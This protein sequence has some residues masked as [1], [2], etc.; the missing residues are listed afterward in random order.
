MSFVF[1]SIGPENKRIVQ[2]EVY[3]KQSLH[4]GSRG[5]FSKQFRSAS[6]ENDTSIYPSTSGSYW[7]SLKVLYYQSASNVNASESVK[8][9]DYT[10]AKTERPSRPQ[11][12]SKFHSSGSVIS[13]PQRY[14]GE[15]IRP[16]SF[17]FR[18]DSGTKEIILQDD[19]FGNLFAPS[20]SESQSADTNISSSD[21]YVG[22]I[23]YNSGVVAITE[24]GSWS[25]SLAY[26]SLTTGSYFIDFESTQTIW[27]HE[28]TLAI[29]PGEFNCT[30]NRTIRGIP[31]GV[32][33]S[34]KYTL[35]NESPFVADYFT[36]SAFSPYIT[37]FLLYSKDVK[38]DKVA[39]QKASSREPIFMAKVPRPIKIR[40]DVKM[41]FKIRVDM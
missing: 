14:I 25:S 17:S 7:N 4:S 20:A 32:K 12:T 8:Y 26:T 24:T 41:I 3:N 35:Q 22:N 10:L 13:I 29:E 34:S 5:I 21:N 16:G 39:G 28:Y 30:M 38:F 6:V 2:R 37:T 1:K 23:F 40:D 11:F 15:G 36:G 27:T 33:S 19:R 9:L 31:G 18:D